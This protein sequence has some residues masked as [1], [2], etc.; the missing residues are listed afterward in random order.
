MVESEKVKP[1]GVRSYFPILTWLPHYQSKWPM[2]TNHAD[3]P[4]TR[5]DHGREWCGGNE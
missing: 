1:K 5:L 2:G 3:Y 4:L